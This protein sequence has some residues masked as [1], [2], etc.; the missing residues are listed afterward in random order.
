[1]LLVLG[2]R[3]ALL[4][5]LLAWS[6]RAALLYGLAV[7]IELHVLNFFDGFHHTFEQFVVEPGQ[8]V[9]IAGRD[10][11]YEQQNT[12]SNLISTRFVWLNALI[13]NLAITT[14]TTTGR[15]C[16]GPQG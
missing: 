9:P 7:L 8:A 4:V 5:M 16:R 10:R 1:M 2:V 13:L 12:Y 11:T 6:P 14:P 15:H 3:V